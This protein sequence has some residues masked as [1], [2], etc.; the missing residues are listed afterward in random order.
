MKPPPKLTISQWA[1]EKRQLSSESSAEPGQ[2]NTSRAEYQRGIMD[3]L[4]DPTIHTVVVKSSA[5]VGKTEI[6]NNVCGYYVDQDPSPILLVLP[7]VEMAQAHS[8]DRL[9]KMIR[10]TDCLRLKFENK[11]KDSSNTIL[12]KEFPGGHITLAGSNSP[13]SLASRPVRIVL[14]D[15]ID[16]FAISAGAEGDPIELADKRTTAFWNRKHYKSSTPTIKGHSRIAE[17]YENSDQRRFYIPCHHCDE[18]YYMVWAGIKWG[19][20]PDGRHDLNKISYLCPHC[21]ALNDERHKRGQIRN[22]IWRPNAAH[23]GIA[24][25][26]LNELY[27][28]WRAWRETAEA[29]LRADKLKKQGDT[30]KLRVWINTAMGE[31]WEDQGETVDHTGL[32]ARREHY[33]ETVPAAAVLLTAAVDVQKD[34]L[35]CEVVAWAE[36]LESWSMAYRV[37]YG[38]PAKTDIWADLDAFLLAEWTHETGLAMKIAC[39]CI[40][41]GGLYTDQVYQYCK[42][43][44]RRR[45]FAIKGRSIA[46][47]PIIGNASTNN[48]YRVRLFPVGSDTAKE[49]VYNYLNVVEPGPGYCHF[50]VHHN[51][52]AY[53]KGLTAEQ[54]VTRY[55][56]GHPVRVWVKPERAANEPLDL[57]AYNLAAVYI[58]NPNWRRLQKLFDAP[59]PPP[60]KPPVE[61]DK[62]VR[63]KQPKAK[64]RRGGFATSWKD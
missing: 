62:A 60:N 2:W 5:Q 41:S 28:P 63:R 51:D 19:K 23:N 59:P 13:A 54:V 3:A 53:F 15:E 25:F 11:T 48:K 31:E 18:R 42:P 7:T 57:R 55:K 39:T 17:L 16:R 58:I 21:G 50:S 43:R 12:H 30:S 40:D 38:D 44:Q 32:M 4:N 36:G 29:F 10:D 52:E 34:R 33:S 6:L 26:W 46:G 9:A 61:D 35:E 22:G 49:L 14:Q 45:I 47:A 56:H 8:K 20:L 37:F 64:K 24:G 27:S 1:D